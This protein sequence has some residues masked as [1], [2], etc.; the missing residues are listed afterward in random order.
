MAPLALDSRT[1]AGKVRSARHAR[2]VTVETAI[3]G[4]GAL[5]LSQGLRDWGWSIAMM[6]N[7]QAG[8]A[9][10]WIPGNAVF[11]IPAADPA[12]GCDPLNAGAES[13]L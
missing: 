2:G 1:H 6:T 8:T 12:N 5:G 13:P 3:D 9:L 4:F 11:E 10:P 7:R